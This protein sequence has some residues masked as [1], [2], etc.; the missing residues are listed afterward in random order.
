MAAGIIWNDNTIRTF[1]V[2]KFGIM[3]AGMT[4]FGSITGVIMT[5]GTFDMMP[6]GRVILGMMRYV[7]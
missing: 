7:A 4:I 2:M 1:G 5:I 6:I 3:T